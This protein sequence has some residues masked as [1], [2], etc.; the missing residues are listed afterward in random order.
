MANFA[1]P[2]PVRLAASLLGSGW[3]WLKV[4]VKALETELREVLVSVGTM[5]PR[6][7]R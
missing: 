4:P 3:A 7:D 5:R 6:I 1:A 2:P